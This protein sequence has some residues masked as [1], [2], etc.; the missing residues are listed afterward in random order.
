MLGRKKDIESGKNIKNIGK[1]Y[2]GN[3]GNIGNYRNI[4]NKEH[5][6]YRKNGMP[7]YNIKQFLSYFKNYICKFMQ[8]NLQHK[9]FHFHLSV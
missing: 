2:I 4:R 9:L 8:A 5:K 3:I 1:I 7:G 6:E